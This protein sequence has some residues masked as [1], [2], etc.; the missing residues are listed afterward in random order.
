M[1]KGKALLVI[2]RRESDHG[3]SFDVGAYIQK[4][5]GHWERRDVAQDN[6]QHLEYD[7]LPLPPQA[8]KLAVG[9]TIRVHVV[10]VFTFHTYDD[11][12]CDVDLEYEK[13]RVL[14]RQAAP[15]YYFKGEK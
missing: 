14:R 3:N 7:V 4:C 11:G 1:I 8:Y 10:F 13:V 2:T 5:G 12:E 15:K 9:E 6:F